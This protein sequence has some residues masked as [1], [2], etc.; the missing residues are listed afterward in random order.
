MNNHGLAWAKWTT[1]IVVFHSKE[2]SLAVLPFSC[3]EAN[4][5][6]V[7]IWHDDSKSNVYIGKVHLGKGVRAKS[8]AFVDTTV[9]TCWHHSCKHPTVHSWE[10]PSKGIDL[11]MGGVS[12]VD[13]HD[14]NAPYCSTI[15]IHFG[16]FHWPKYRY[17]IGVGD[18]NLHYTMLVRKN[19]LGQIYIGLEHSCLNPT[20]MYIT[21]IENTL[22]SSSWY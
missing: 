9:L 10:C 19:S 16:R 1:T 3:F 11:G 8:F 15:A 20:T 6:S 18:I 12:Y 7:L 17:L 5:L 2:Q 22:H 14:S 13:D 4:V 21:Y